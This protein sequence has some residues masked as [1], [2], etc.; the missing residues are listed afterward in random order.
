M[1]TS[2]GLNTDI[3]LTNIYSLLLLALGSSLTVLREHVSKATL[4]AIL[5]V[6]VGRHEDSRAADRV[7]ANATQASDL[8]L[9]IDLVVLE[10]M[11]LDL[12]VLDLLGLGVRLLLALLA[13]A[14]Q[15]QHQVEGRLLLDVVVRKGAAVLE[16]LAPC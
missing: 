16:L 15:A 1:L 14:T 10:N 8:A 11:K 12:L 9:A 2:L 7:V 5:A 4:S 3:N 13:T 6:E